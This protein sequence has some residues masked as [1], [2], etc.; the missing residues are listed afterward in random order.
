MFSHKYMAWEKAIA[1]AGQ[2]RIKARPLI[3]DVLPLSEWERGFRRFQNKE[4]LKVI[5]EPQRVD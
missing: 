4:A 2:G 5:F 1:M 3:T